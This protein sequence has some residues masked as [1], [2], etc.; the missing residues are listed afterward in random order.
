[1]SREA[2]APR[3][4]MRAKRMLPDA[5]TFSQKSRP[6]AIEADS[7]SREAGA[8]LAGMRAKRML[9]DADTPMWKLL[10]VV[11]EAEA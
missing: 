5:D 1:M 2:G 4:G 6:V 3:A 8:P 9:P 10:A 11:S 7:M